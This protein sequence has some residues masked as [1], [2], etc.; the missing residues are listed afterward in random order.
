MVNF[1]KKSHYKKRPQFFTSCSFRS[2]LFRYILPVI[3]FVPQKPG[4]ISALG[5]G[6]VMIELA[7]PTDPTLKMIWCLKVQFVFVNESFSGWWQLKYFLVSPRSLGKWFPFWL[8]FFKW[9]ETTNQFC[10]FNEKS[11]RWVFSMY[12]SDLVFFFL[13]GDP[14]Q[15]NMTIMTFVCLVSVGGVFTDSTIVISPW[16]TTLSGISSSFFSNHRTSKSKYI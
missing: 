5:H 11:G 15:P 8:I 12:F 3:F 4:A 9:V 7:M 10:L 14:S 1:C 6:E 16:K 2:W 13:I